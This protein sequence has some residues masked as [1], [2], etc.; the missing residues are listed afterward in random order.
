VRPEIIAFRELDTLVRNLTDQLAGYRR[1]ALSAESRVR[2]LE[3]QVAS[4]EQQLAE[5]KRE[6]ATIAES[7]EHALAAARESTAVAKA[8]KESL[9][10]LQQAAAVAT[11]ST[12][13]TEAASSSVV[14]SAAAEGPVAD[15]NARLKAKLADAK[16]RT[17]KLAERVRFLRQ[18]LMAGAD[19]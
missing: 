11:A 12:A 6:T 1:R 9:A 8:A 16:E 17:T 2:E 15:E 4:A 10:R 7:R 14:E 5:S 13:K 19:R 3:V 18:Q